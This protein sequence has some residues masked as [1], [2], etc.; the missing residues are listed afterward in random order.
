MRESRGSGFYL[1]LDKK[2]VGVFNAN[3]FAHNIR[4]KQ[5]RSAFDAL[6]K[7]GICSPVNYHA[8][9]ISRS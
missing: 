8:I 6:D 1:W 9:E 7:T 3:L 4:P 2:V 5:K